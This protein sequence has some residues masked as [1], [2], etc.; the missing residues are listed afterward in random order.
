MGEETYRRQDARPVLRCPVLDADDGRRIVIYAND[1]LDPLLERLV[2]ARHPDHLLGANLCRYE[3]M[4]GCPVENDGE[5]EEGKGATRRR[6]YRAYWQ[7]IGRRKAVERGCVVGLSKSR[8][9]TKGG[10]GAVVAFGDA[11]SRDLL[12]NRMGS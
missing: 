11:A 5:P 1:I 3:E 10:R 12:Y 7:A 9:R 6:V 4:A 8:G 2:A